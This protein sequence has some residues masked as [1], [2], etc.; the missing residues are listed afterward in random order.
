M[1][2]FPGGKLLAENNIFA[3]YLNGDQELQTSRIIAKARK[4]GIHA[5]SAASVMVVSGSML[6]NGAIQE[7]SRNADK[8][9]AVPYGYTPQIADASLKAQ[10]EASAGWQQVVTSCTSNQ[11]GQV[12]KKPGCLNKLME[13]SPIRVAACKQAANPGKVLFRVYNYSKANVS[14][15]IVDRDGGGNNHTGPVMA[16]KYVDFTRD[17]QVNTN[18]SFKVFVNLPSFTST[19]PRLGTFTLNTADL[20]TCL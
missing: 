3:P 13:K 1:A 6:T 17:V 12:D 5:A 11:L 4:N 18:L 2:V 14:N 8:I 16:R 7:A 20:P 19:T 10:L 9:F 15:V